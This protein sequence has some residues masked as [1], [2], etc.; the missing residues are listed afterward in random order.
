VKFIRECARRLKPRGIM[1]SR[2]P[3]ARVFL[4]FTQVFPYVLR[5][6]SGLV[7]IGSSRPLRVEPD[8]WLARLRSAEVSAYLG[9][10]LVED[11]ASMLVDFDEVPHR[12]NVLP[13]RLN[14]DLFPRDEFQVP[15]SQR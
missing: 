6:R 2:A 10:R 7:A 14:L 12:R 15:L 5:D 1:C 8:A 11:V 13:E 9:P 3:T 4:S